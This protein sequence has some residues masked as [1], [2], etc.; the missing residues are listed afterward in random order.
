V[1]QEGLARDSRKAQHPH[2]GFLKFDSIEVKRLTRRRLP[3]NVALHF[4]RVTEQ[5]FHR[6]IDGAIAEFSIIDR[7]T[8]RTPLPHC[9][10]SDPSALKT[11]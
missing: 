2:C 4:R 6:H 3:H 5:H 1:Y 10:T 7:A 8:Q 9:S 11:R